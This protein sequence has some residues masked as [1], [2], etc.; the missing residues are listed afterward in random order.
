MPIVPCLPEVPSHEQ[1]LASQAQDAWRVLQFQT[2]VLFL[3]VVRGVEA[4]N[5]RGKVSIACSTACAQSFAD[6]WPLAR[7]SAQLPQDMVQ[8]SPSSA[9][10]A[11]RA[12]RQTLDSHLPKLGSLDITRYLA[13][14]CFF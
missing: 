10:R 4:I 8:A 2:D 1:A 3:D 11:R 9:S 5:R 13:C 12:G 6:V 7:L 14:F